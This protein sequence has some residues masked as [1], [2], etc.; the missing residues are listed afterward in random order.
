MAGCSQFS[1]VRTVRIFIDNIAG[2]KWQYHT[3]CGKKRLYKK[4][5]KL[6]LTACAASIFL[7]KSYRKRNAR[8]DKCECAGAMD[9]LGHNYSFYWPISQSGK[10][11]ERHRT[12][13][14]K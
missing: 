3:Y 2:S 5:D 10:E 4:E 7:E 8:C 14:V 12:V 6:L 13:V 1:F 9:I 11:Y